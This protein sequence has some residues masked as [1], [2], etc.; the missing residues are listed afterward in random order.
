MKKSVMKSMKDVE[1]GKEP[2]GAVTVCPDM[3]TAAEIQAL[4]KVHELK[5]G[6]LLITKNTGGEDIKLTGA[7]T[8][9]LPYQGNLALVEAVLAMSTGAT[10]NDCGMT[11]VKANNVERKRKKENAVT[12]RIMVVKGLLSHQDMERMK[13]EPTYALHL[14]EC[15]KML[16]E[17]KTSGWSEQTEVFVGYIEAEKS[18]SE[19]LLNLSGQGGVFIS[20]LRKDVIEWPNVTWRLPE[21]NESM[22]LYHLRILKIARELGKPLAF[23]R[24]GGAAFGVVMPAAD[25]DEHIH[26]WSLSGAPP[27][28][29]PVTLREWLE[30][31]GWAVMDTTQ[32]R[33]RHLPWSFRGRMAGKPND[34]SFSYEVE[35]EESNN[36]YVL[37]KRWEKRRQPDESTPIAG[38][39]QRWWHKSATFDPIEEDL[40]ATWPDGAEE[41]PQPTIMDATAE[42]ADGDDNMNGNKR[43]Q[44][45]EKPQNGT[46]PPKKKSKQG[47]EKPIKPDYD[48]VAGGMP[49]PEAQGRRTTVID[50]GGRG[51][52]GWRALSF[53]VAGLN[54]AAVTDE[55]LIDKLDPLAKTMQVRVTSHLIQHKK[56]WQDA[57]APDPK[58]NSTMEDGSIPTSVSEYCEAVQRPNRWVDGLLL[59]TAAILQRINIIVWSKRGGDWVKIAILKSGPEWR[60]S[61]TVPL[62][63]SRGH[64]MTL[65]H[66]KGHWPKEWVVEAGD[67]IPCSQGLD[68]QITEMNPALGRGGM[69]STPLNKIRKKIEETE[70]DWASLLR[71]CSS[72]PSSKRSQNAE[73]EDL[74][75]PCSVRTSTGSAEIENMLRPCT[76]SQSSKKAKSLKD[77]KASADKRDLDYLLRTCSSYRSTLSTGKKK[78][79]EKEVQRTKQRGGPGKKRIRR[80]NMRI[81]VKGDTKT[82]KC[83]FCEE[84]LDITK[85][86]KIDRKK[87]EIHLS[88]QH[89]KILEQDRKKN[90]KFGRVRTGLGLR[91]LTWPIEFVKMSK[92]DMQTKAQFVCPLCD[93]CMPRLSQDCEVQKRKYLLRISKMHHLGKCK[94]AGETIS[95]REYQS[96]YVK[97]FPEIYQAASRSTLDLKDKVKSPKIRTGLGLVSHTSPIE[98]VE[99]TQSDMQKKAQFVCP[100]CDMC[101]PKQPQN[102]DE[103][104]MQY[105]I[106]SS[107]IHHLGKCKRAEEN[108]SLRE[109]QSLYVKKYP[110]IYRTAFRST[111][112]LKGKDERIQ[113][114]ISLGHDPVV[115]EFANGGNKAQ[116]GYWMMICK[117]CRSLLRPVHRRKLEC[118]GKVPLKTSPGF[119]FWKAADGEGVIDET[120]KKLGMKTDEVAFVKAALENKAAQYWHVESMPWLRGGMQMNSEDAIFGAPLAF[121]A[122]GNAE[123]ATLDGEVIGNSQEIGK[124]ADEHQCWTLNTGGLGGVWRLINVL[125]G[126]D[127]KKRPKLVHLQ[128]TSCDGEQWKT[129]ERHFKTIGFKAYHTMG[130]LDSKPAYGAWKRGII[131][132]V[133]EGL[134]SKWMEE[135]TWRN[136]QF[137]AI[138]V[139]G[140]MCLNSYVKPSEDCIQRQLH[141]MQSFMTKTR[142]EGRWLCGGD[143]NEEWGGSWTST[144]ASL[145]EGYQQ[146]TCPTTSS[147]WDSSSLIDYWFSNFDIGKVDRRDERISDHCIITTKVDFGTLLDE[148]Y[149]RFVQEKQFRCPSWMSPHKRHLLFQEAFELGEKLEWYDAIIKVEEMEWPEEVE[150]KDIINYQWATV[151]SKITWALSVASG[152][153][154][155][156]VPADFEDYREIQ[157]VVDVANCRK[158]K[159]VTIKLQKRVLQKRASRVSLAMRKLYKRAGRLSTLAKSML[160]N[161]VDTEVI[162][163]Q[164]KLFP[165]LAWSEL[166]RTMVREELDRVKHCISEKEAS[167]KKCSINS[168]KRRMHKGMKERSNWI[169]KQGSQKSPMVA[170]DQCAKTR[171]EGASKLRSYW[172]NL[173]Q[174]Q[175]WDDEERK[176]KAKNIADSINAKVIDKVEG[177]RPSLEEFKKGLKRISGTHGNRWMVGLWAQSHSC[178]G[179]GSGD[180]MGSHGVVG[181]DWHHPRLHC[182]L[183]TCMCAEKGQATT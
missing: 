49:G 25:D 9:L 89:P 104:K 77:A 20:H 46:S 167:E 170:D 136:G 148:E 22:Q 48:R 87:V 100:L 91:E 90:A 152:Y 181:A 109:Y 31:Q 61:H 86:D 24:G 179:Q 7:R 168:W 158:V 63:L 162:N 120:G 17:L 6:I 29:G 154:L 126:M 11:P 124:A 178:C 132:A 44:N 116:Y 95:L 125:K 169:N 102:C 62:I 26:S 15:G 123:E 50:T 137:H 164:K 78:E 71:P 143:W 51:N 40:T 94:R 33:K 118:S 150:E 145:F 182:S 52:C 144:F 2:T 41:E 121:S 127:A 159:G 18:E 146:E 60:R 42:D 153:A 107:K 14:M 119:A 74:L 106:R 8:T 110:E 75:K 131:T 54:N 130:T 58:T 37:V 66:Q 151:C 176:E 117:S 76:L 5:T 103:K 177:A 85:G 82:W 149:T 129:V 47:G 92:K 156:S 180:G 57:W 112:D 4:S 163:L 84:V 147:R 43:E 165:H 39:G 174:K 101:L 32:P 68:T 133:S 97:K 36:F 115:I 27:S 142:W 128:E 30:K 105:L 56:H 155:N 10:P 139:H 59:A 161:R 135:Y 34:R 3:K 160:R 53:A 111:L 157:S 13:T 80:P 28:W 83:P 12:L 55:A 21:G 73:I 88:R 96:L 45:A 70:D 108:I 114:M 1:V 38:A 69:L 99:M 140:V 173:W 35:G 183:Q 72:R 16:E 113:R 175:V 67:D 141:E 134:K 79:Q 93:M 171:Q 81:I 64:F 166:S 19:M 98:F 65:R 172:Q 23:R 122:Q 138:E